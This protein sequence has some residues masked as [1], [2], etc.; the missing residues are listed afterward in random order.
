MTD[1]TFNDLRGTFI[2]RRRVMGWTAEETALCSGHPI[3]G[4]KGAQGAYVDRAAVALANA[5]RLWERFYGP[6]S[7]QKLQTGLQTGEPVERLSH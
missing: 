4:E 5:N 1:R 7:E 6:N 2:S 3:A